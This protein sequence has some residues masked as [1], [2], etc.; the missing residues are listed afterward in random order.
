MTSNIC[1]GERAIVM[2]VVSVDPVA[3]GKKTGRVRL[4][5]KRVAGSYAGNA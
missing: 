1:R 4:F 5:D 2:P 3:A